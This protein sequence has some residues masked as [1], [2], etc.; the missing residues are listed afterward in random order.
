MKKQVCLAS[1]I[2]WLWICFTPEV[3]RPTFFVPDPSGSD[4]LL[5]GKKLALRHCQ[6]CHLY[7]EPG[8]LDKKTWREGVLPNMGLRLG[9]ASPGDLART[10]LAPAE[11]QV[12]AILNI[13]PSQAA[14]SLAEWK[15]ICQYFEHEAPEALPSVAHPALDLDHFTQFQSYYASFSTDQ[16]PR[17]TLIKFDLATRHFF[18][19]DA[20]NELYITNGHFQLVNQAPTQSPASDIDFPTAQS[21]RLLTIGSIAPSDLQQ[22]ELLSLEGTPNALRIA[23][24]G[25]PVQFAA[26]DLNQYGAEDLVICSF[27]NHQGKLAWY[28]EGLASKERILSTLPGFRRVEIQDLNGD[29]KNDVIA[30]RTQAYEAISIFYNLGKGRFE[31]KTVLQFPPVYGLSY[32]ETADFNRDGHLDILLTNGDNWDYSAILKPYHGIRIYLNNGK[33]QFKEA[34]FYPLYGTSKAMARDFDQDGD[35]D[36]AAIAFY[37]DL[38]QPERGFVYLQNQGQLQF[39]PQHTA[40]AAAGKWLT[41]ESGDFDRDGDQDIV[42]GSYFHT[43]AE[44][45]QLAQR[46]ITAFPQL[47]V[48]Y[49]QKQNK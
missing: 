21:P 5:M 37:A 6:T 14:L 4:S 22:G 45:T 35:L 2:L 26:G 38:E 19:G 44:I 3:E 25:R 32:F 34:F 20:K 8:L 17:T 24:L 47:L 30:L 42:L 43:A 9:I 31:E 39:E 16:F 49:N 18:I 23:P 29:K 10:P 11:A 27:G 40:A 36:I 13:Y 1:L 7:P 48:L 33:N 41:M 12:Q 28:E 15:L 46:G